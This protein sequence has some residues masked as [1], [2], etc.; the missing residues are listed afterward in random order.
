MVRVYRSKGKN[1]KGQ[2]ARGKGR[3]TRSKGQGAKDLGLTARQER[4]CQELRSHEGNVT[5]AAVAA[6]YSE[7]TAGR[8]GHELLHKPKVQER[9]EFLANEDDK[10]LVMTIRERR[11]WLT[12]Q[13][14]NP[15][16][17]FRERCMAIDVLNKLD[18][19][20]SIK[21]DVE[22]SAKGFKVLKDKVAGSIA[23]EKV[24]DVEAEVDE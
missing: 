1:N 13:A 11:R 8:I 20:Y 12:A 4:F 5:A 17:K 21:L 7:K 24:L 2:G 16:L 9:L 14:R 6:G 10:S 23:R 18:G 3:G 22:V 15:G 19:A